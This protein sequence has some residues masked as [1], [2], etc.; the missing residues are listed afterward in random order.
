LPLTDDT[1]VTVETIEQ[2]Q[3]SLADA[4]DNTTIVLKPGTYRLQRTLSV[5]ADDI[6]IRGPD[7]QCD[8]VQLMGAGMDNPD[9][10][11]VTFGFWINARNTTIANLS[12]RDVYLHAIQI[13][14]SAHA[15]R[16]YN[17][18]LVDAGQQFIKSNPTASGGGV[19]EGVVEYSTIEYSSGP[20][21][22][23]HENAGI[24][25]T[26]GVDVHSGQGWRISNNVFRNLHTPDTAD[27]LWNAAVLVWRGASQTITENNF[28]LRV[29]RAIAYGLGDM[30]RDH[31]GGVI[32]NNVVVMPAGL[33]SR[34]R[35]RRADAPVVVWQSPG[36]QVLHNTILTNGNMPFAIESRFDATD[37]TL[38][39]NLTDAPVVHS[40]GDLLRNLCKYKTIC[41]Q[42]VTRFSDQ[43]VTNADPAW[44]VDIEAGN[45]RLKNKGAAQ[46]VTLSRFSDAAHDSAG[47][48]RDQ[49]VTA[50][51]FE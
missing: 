18:H 19:D 48:A 39:N 4:E 2:L 16:I 51:A 36:T 10:Q 31:T 12:I 5:T 41:R 49:R 30:P 40:D 33:Y 6:T 8:Q 13:D 43:N 20:P 17:V 3:S 14:G 25:Y 38:A 7:N 46:K 45:A 32:R 24:G 28:F 1:V 15:P 29:D 26:N 35:R 37:V 42:Y 34:K 23:D 11:G 9:H 50:G 22:T 47:T 44:F 27:H 21:L